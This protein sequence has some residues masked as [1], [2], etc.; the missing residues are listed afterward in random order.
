M[1]LQLSASVCARLDCF[2]V[3]TLRFS[4]TVAPTRKARTPAY[5]RM[6]SFAI[7]SR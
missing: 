4:M 1:T 5:L 2:R 3:H 6:P 7:T